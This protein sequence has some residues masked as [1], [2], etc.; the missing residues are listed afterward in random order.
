MS[1]ENL[2]LKKL[3]NLAIQNHQNNNYA[4]AFK[5]YEKILKINPD[6]FET[7]FYLGTLYAQ[8]NNLKKASELLNK[9]IEINPDIADLHNNL[10][11]IFREMGEL[12]KASKCIIKAIQINYWISNLLSRPMVSNISSSINLFNICI[13]WIR[14]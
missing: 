8:N 13:F 7:N 3:L 2:E 10:G 14:W 9:A 11:L 5:I 6:H 12:E 1:N 4:E